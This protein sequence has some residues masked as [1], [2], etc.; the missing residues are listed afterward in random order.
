MTIRGEFGSKHPSRWW[1]FV[2]RPVVFYEFVQKEEEVE[3]EQEELGHV[4][5]MAVATRSN[6]H[7]E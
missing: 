7:Q 1:R 6:L 5:E 3:D 2:M 4:P